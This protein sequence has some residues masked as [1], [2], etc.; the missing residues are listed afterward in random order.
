MIPAHH[1]DTPHR[2]QLI[3]DEIAKCALDYRYEIQR[4][5]KIRTKAATL[6]RLRFNYAQLRLDELVRRQEKARLPVRVIAV[7]PRKVGLSTYIQARFLQRCTKVKNQRSLTLAHDGDTTETL[8]AITDL[9]YSEMPEHLRPM[10]RYQNRG[11]ILFENPDPITRTIR[12]GLRSHLRIGTAGKIEAGRG[13]DI[14]LLHCSESPFWPDPERTELSL[15]NAVPS[16]PGTMVFKEST[17]N[18]VGDKFHNDYKAAKAGQSAFVPYFLA[19]HEFPEYQMPLNVEP[20]RFIDSIDPEERELK[21]AYHLSLEQLNWRRWTIE[22]QC[23]RDETKFQQEY[24]ANDVECFLVSGRTRFNGKRLHARLAQCRDEVVRGDLEWE[25]SRVTIIEN[26]RGATRMWKPPALASRYLIGADVAEGLEHGDYSVAHVYDWDTGELVCEWHGHIE[27]WSFG[28][29]LAKLGR[30]YN[31]AL[32]ACE[33]NKDGGTVNQRLKND[34][35]PHLYWRREEDTRGKARPRLGWLTTAKTK[36]MMVNA[37]G[38]ALY[39]DD[40]VLPSSDL[41]GEAMTF[42][43]HS[44]GSLGA[45]SGC[46]DDRVIASAIAFEV[47]K[48]QGME[49]VYASLAGG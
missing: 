4:H 33:A 26:D 12:P 35:Y 46:H 8:F 39:A 32:I 44:D 6:T 41:I 28:D 16:L 25:G 47:R 27:P 18:G 20:E 42:V 17:P 37:L 11:E 21:D 5:Y 1:I 3:R 30:I 38:E 49:S 36:P 2:R 22:N 31:N 48:R 40:I 19:W 14:H 9:F 10:V 43:V 34:A 15:F 29:E 24:P 13:T 7:K 45:Q 23:G